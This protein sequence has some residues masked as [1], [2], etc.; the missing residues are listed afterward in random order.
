MRQTQSHN[1][2]YAGSAEKGFPKGSV[3]GITIHKQCHSNWRLAKQLL[4]PVGDGMPSAQQPPCPLASELP[5]IA[6]PLAPFLTLCPAQ[7]PTPPMGTPT[8]PQQDSPPA[9]LE[10]DTMRGLVTQEVLL[11]ADAAAALALP[12]VLLPRHRTYQLSEK[13][14]LEMTGVSMIGMLTQLN[15][16]GSALKKIEASG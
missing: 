14:V 10:T 2:A 4:A 15:L 7:T 1:K 12:P 3:S 8:L 5:H 13:G 11:N 9:Q 16:H 6:A